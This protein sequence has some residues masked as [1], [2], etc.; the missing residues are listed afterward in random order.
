MGTSEPSRTALQPTPTINYQPI[1]LADRAC[2]IAAAATLQRESCECNFVNLYA[3][4]NLYQSL[5]T[6]WQGRIVVLWRTSNML[7]FPQGA[8]LPPVELERIRRQTQEEQRG[9]LVWGDVPCDYIEAH[10]SELEQLYRISQP[11]GDADYI[12]LVDELAAVQGQ[13]H[14][15]TRRLLRQFEEQYPDGEL[16]DVAAGDLPAI[17]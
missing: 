10:R 1:T 16:Q 17:L 8:W 15:N 13:Q 11:E 9:H 6:L 7:L 12:Y 3:W 5:Y 14:Q 4:R 2:F